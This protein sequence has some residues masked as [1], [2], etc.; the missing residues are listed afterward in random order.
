MIGITVG[1]S[2]AK[3]G[4]FFFLEKIFR[5]DPKWHCP[6]CLHYRRRRRCPNRDCWVALFAPCSFRL[7]ATRIEPKSFLFVGRFYCRHCAVLAVARRVRSTTCHRSLA[8]VRKT[9]VCSQTVNRCSLLSS[10]SSRA[11]RTA[12]A[13][14]ASNALWIERGG[15]PFSFGHSH[16]CAWSSCAALEWFQSARIRSWRRARTCD[17]T[18]CSDRCASIEPPAVACHS[19]TS[20]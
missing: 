2:T 5:T 18:K 10:R 14:T 1:V 15:A 16:L 7:N 3:S 6:E 4:E 17:T 11:A 20:A 13:P 8:T 12:R 19:W 9:L